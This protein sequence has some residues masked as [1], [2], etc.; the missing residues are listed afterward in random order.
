MSSFLHKAGCHTPIRRTVCACVVGLVL[1]LAGCGGQ[2][3]DPMANGGRIKPME[4]I[5][6][7]S[8]GTS[9][10]LPVPGTVAREDPLTLTPTNA[11]QPAPVT[12]AL[13]ERGRERYMIHCSPCHGSL[14]DGQGMIVLRG[15]P[16]PPS[17]HIDRLRQ[18]PDSHMFD[19]ITRGLGK[20]LP[21]GP[22]VPVADRW[23]IIA[24]VRAL[25]RSQ[26]TPVES[27]SPQQRKQL[28]M[29]P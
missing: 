18:A 12:L 15:F 27:I 10:R 23:A 11:S 1:L 16:A 17:Y 20:M 13:L 26:W 24:Y 19:V 2:G 14:G 4:P 3:S 28:E 8:D 7:F 22:R 5:A 9:A 6:F 21:Y 29:Q 25:Q